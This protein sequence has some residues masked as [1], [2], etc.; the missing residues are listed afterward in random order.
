MPDRDRVAAQSELERLLGEDVPF[1]DLTTHALAIRDKPGRMEFR[2]RFP[3]VL[4]LVQDAAAVI[5]LAGAE[6]TVHHHSGSFVEAGGLVL[7]ATGPAGSLLKSWKVAQTMIECWSGVATATHAIVTAARAVTQNVT[8]ACTRK[9]I[10]GTRRFAAAAI[11]A[12]GGTMHRLGLSETILVFPEHRVFLGEEPLATTALRLRSAAPE[13]KLVIEVT[14][15]EEGLAAADAGFDVIQTEKFSPVDLARLAAALTRLPPRPV[16]AAAGGINASNA[17]DYARA[18]ADVLVT[19][20]P[21]AAPPRDIAVSI[22]S[23]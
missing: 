22:L 17:A 1:G 3:I 9:S 11:A 23:A 14:S 6:A 21:F 8:V 4:A 2:A 13:K 5:E 12:G 16:L 19:S 18:G 10:P 15:H 20:A 7:T